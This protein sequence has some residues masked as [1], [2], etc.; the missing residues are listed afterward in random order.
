MSLNPLAGL[1]ELPKVH[2]NHNKHAA[3]YLDPSAFDGILLDHARITGS[4]S[5]FHPAWVN[6]TVM[7]AAVALAVKATAASSINRAVGI[8]LNTNGCLPGATGKGMGPGT[9]CEGPCIT[10]GVAKFRA[11]LQAAKASIDAA[12]AALGSSVPVLSVTLDC[13]GGWWLG[14]DHGTPANY[15]GIKLHNELIF[16]TS[17]SVFARPTAILNYMY[18]NAEWYPLGHGEGDNCKVNGTHTTCDALECNRT[19]AQFA[20]G[21]GKPHVPQYGSPQSVLTPGWCTRPAPA[22]WTERYEHDTPFVPSLYEVNAPMMTIERFKYTAALARFKGNYAV[23]PYIAL[24]QSWK[25][26]YRPHKKGAGDLYD[27]QSKYNPAY[28]AQ[29]GAYVNRPEFERSRFGPWEQVTSAVIYQ[30]AF[31]RQ[32]TEDPRLPTTWNTMVHFVAYVKGAAGIDLD[33]WP[34]AE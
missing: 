21:A 34:G 32:P 24:G 8:N 33:V 12:N 26:T 28:S 15:P 5:P 11:D 22:V 13:E 4:I 31:A 10:N 27:V 2:H 6:L 30:G 29:I 9:G 14:G 16:N 18:G 20:I 17:R 19:W 7:T 1:P 3:E 23:V 25:A